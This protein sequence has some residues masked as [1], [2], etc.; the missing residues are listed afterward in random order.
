MCHSTVPNPRHIADLQKK[1]RFLEDG[2]LNCV[3]EISRTNHSVNKLKQW[4]L[5]ENLGIGF[6]FVCSDLPCF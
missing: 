4:L 1:P 5:M 2:S 3:V 6:P